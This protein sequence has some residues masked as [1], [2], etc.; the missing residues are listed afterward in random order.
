MSGKIRVRFLIATL[1]AP[2]LLP[3]VVYCLV[4]LGAGL[5]VSATL[6]ALVDQTGGEKNS[7]ALISA[8]GLAPA[9]LLLVLVRALRWFDPRDAWRIASGWGGLTAILLVLAWANFEAWPHFLPGRNYPGWPHGLELVIAPLFFAPVAMV[10]GALGAG[11][12]AAY[13]GRAPVPPR[14]ETPQPPDA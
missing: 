2:L 4:A 11:L 5:G 10:F 1:V 6:K 3:A 13:G 14:P 7:L 12:V 9:M 8:L